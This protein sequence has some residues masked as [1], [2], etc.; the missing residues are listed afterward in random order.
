MLLTT[1][2]A[3]GGYWQWSECSQVFCDF[4][5]A[6]W[7]QHSNPRI[8]IGQ[9]RVRMEFHSQWFL[10]FPDPPSV[11]PCSSALKCKALEAVGYLQCGWVVDVLPAPTKLQVTALFFV[12]TQAALDSFRCFIHRFQ[13]QSADI[14]NTSN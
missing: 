5:T 12:W 10:E 14:Q 13:C 7:G 1:T 2:S 6:V 8:L 9:C 11:L 4:P 3:S